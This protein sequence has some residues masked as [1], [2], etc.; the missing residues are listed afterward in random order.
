MTTP[1]DREVI[2]E[3]ANRD[4]PE[5]T[6]EEDIP[7]RGNESGVEHYAET[8][9]IENLGTQKE[10]PMEKARFFAG[11]SI[12]NKMICFMV[13]L[14]VLDLIVSIL[15][16]ESNLIESAFDTL[17]LVVMTVL[18]YLFGTNNVSENKD[19]SAK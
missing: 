19:A 13:A 10:M 16:V 14:V 1:S 17:K 8:H 15:K 2:E 6:S 5:I 7:L 9:N 18:G 11:V 3:R 12:L 4:V